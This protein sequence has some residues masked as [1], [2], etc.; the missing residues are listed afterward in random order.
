M[1]R[2]LDVNGDLDFLHFAIFWIFRDLEGAVKM[3]EV[4]EVVLPPP[5]DDQD[6]QGD[7]DGQEVEAGKMEE[8]QIKSDVAEVGV[9]KE[10]G[11]GEKE[12]RTNKNIFFLIDNYL[13]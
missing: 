7:Q 2:V 4:E 9:D 5:Q 1:T 12:A 8:G 11:S 13:F 6:D 3:A 10:G